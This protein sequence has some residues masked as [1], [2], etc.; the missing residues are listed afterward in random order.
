[1]QDS[2]QSQEK[3]GGISAPVMVA[4]LVG[5]IL[6]AVAAFFGIVLLN[7]FE[8]MEAKVTELTQQVEEAGEKSEHALQQSQ[9]AEA[10]AVEAARGRVRAEAE[11]EHALNE[12]ESAKQQMK[13]AEVDADNAREEAR[14]AQEEAERIRQEWEA[15]VNRLEDALSQIVETRKTALGLVLNL[16]EDYLKFDFDKSDL[17]PANREL[18]SRIAGILLTS[19]DYSVGV[20]GHT[21][22]VGTAEYNQKLSERRAAVVRDYLV[23]AGLDPTIVTMEGFGKTQPLVPE[24]TDEARAKNR[25]V[26]IGIINTRINYNPK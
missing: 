20:Y 7:R 18:L 11:A 9:E 10:S 15:E 17:K 23:E 19:K 24:K 6:L 3:K 14:I 13:A 4:L 22:D 26:E 25:R 1:M 21:D 8:E 5:I 16:S 2:N 12:A